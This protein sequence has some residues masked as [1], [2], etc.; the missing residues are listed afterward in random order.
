IELFLDGAR[1][2]YVGE[3]RLGAAPPPLLL[4]DDRLTQL[5]ALAADIDVA[6]AFHEG[7]DLAIA[8]AAEGTVGVAVAPGAPGGLAPPS[9]SARVFRRHAVSFYLVSALV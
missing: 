5:D 4:I 1:R 2:G 8:L 6:G 9:P 3:E 7:A